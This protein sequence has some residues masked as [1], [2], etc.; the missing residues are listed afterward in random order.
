M[1]WSR[2]PGRNCVAFLRNCVVGPS[3]HTSIVIFHWAATNDKWGVGLLRAEWELLRGR[4]Y[5][6]H[7][8]SV[9]NRLSRPLM[10]KL[11]RAYLPEALVVGELVLEKRSFKWLPARSYSLV[12]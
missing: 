3:V 7:H 11:S 4:S 1:W 2:I 10:Y 5:P 8:L 6:L 12:Q 9:G